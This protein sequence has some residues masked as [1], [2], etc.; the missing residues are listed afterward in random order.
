VRISSDPAITALINNAGVASFGSFATLSPG[1]LDETT[2]VNITA[3]TRLTHA[4][5]PGFLAR[6]AGSI[7]NIASV[8]ALGELAVRGSRLV[9]WSFGVKNVP[10]GLE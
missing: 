9:P 2:A 6:G 8:L 1:A 10:D 7:V 3:L 5:L 4:V